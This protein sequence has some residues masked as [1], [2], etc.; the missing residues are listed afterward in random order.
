[1]TSDGKPVRPL[2]YK[3][4]VKERYALSKYCNIP[5]HDSLYISP[6]ERKYILE[7]WDSDIQAEKKQAEA[8]NKKLKHKAR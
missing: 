1:M 2:L 3:K 8:Q 6:L 5:Y 7:F 4:I